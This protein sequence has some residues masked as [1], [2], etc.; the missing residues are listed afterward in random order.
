MFLTASQANGT[1]TSGKKQQIETK[2]LQW[3]INYDDLYSNSMFS[4]NSFVEINDQK[5]AASDG[6]RLYL[7]EN[8]KIIKSFDLKAQALVYIK[9]ISQIVVYCSD[10]SRL[11]FVWT[12]PPYKARI[13]PFNFYDK[14]INAM[15]YFEKS[16]VLIS[17]GNGIHFTHLTIPSQFKNSEPVP[18]ML[19]FEKICDL[20]EDIKYSF[21][22]QPIVSI[23]NEL[24]FVLL[25][26]KIFVHRSNGEL[27]Q[28]I[29]EIPGPFPLLF[30]YSEILESLIITTRDGK[31]SAL[32]FDPEETEIDYDCLQ[33]VVYYNLNYD[34]VKFVK[35]YDHN[36]MVAITQDKKILTVCIKNNRI[37]DV[38]RLKKE[39]T[40]VMEG[41]NFIYV[42]SESSL[43]R[44]K[45]NF[46]SH[47]YIEEEREIF[48]LKRCSSINF[49]ARLFYSTNTALINF[50]SRRTKATIAKIL[51]SKS[52][53]EVI[54]MIYP[55]DLNNDGETIV[56]SRQSDSLYI[57]FSKG[58]VLEINFDPI[59]YQQKQ[60]SSGDQYLVT[61]Q[62]SEIDIRKTPV[63]VISIPPDIKFVK[64]INIE[65]TKMPPCIGLI[66]ELGAICLFSLTRRQFFCTFNTQCQGVLTAIFSNYYQLIVISYVNGVAVIDPVTQSTVTNIKTNPITSL[67]MIDKNTIACGSANGT[68]EIREFPSFRL[69]YT[70]QTYGT[71]H[72][73]VS[74]SVNTGI[75]ESQK[76]LQQSNAIV[77]MDLCIQRKLILTAS[78]SGEVYL[79]DENA[80]PTI[81]LD[82]GFD[83]TSC[84]FLNGNGTIVFS[85]FNTIFKIS[86]KIL[87]DNRLVQKQLQLDDFDLRI[88]PFEPGS[89]NI[90][91]KNQKG[92]A[93]RQKTIRLSKFSS[94]E[95][96]DDFSYN[97]NSNISEFSDPQF[98]DLDVDNDAV[99][100]PKH[101][102]VESPERFR[103][104][105]PNL[106]LGADQ[107][108]EEMMRKQREA[109]EAAR[110]KK[111]TKITRT[112]SRRK[113]DENGN[114]IGVKSLYSQEPS[115]SLNNKSKSPMKLKDQTI[116]FKKELKN[117]SLTS[118][119]NKTATF[120]FD[121]NKEQNKYNQSAALSRS[122]PYNISLKKLEKQTMKR[123]EKE[124]K[125]FEKEK[126]KGKDIFEKLNRKPRE[127][128]HRQV[129][130]GKEN[131]ENTDYSTKWNGTDMVEKIPSVPKTIPNMLSSP[132][133][134][135][136]PTFASSHISRRRAESTDNSKLDARL[137]YVTPDFDNDVITEPA[138]VAHEKSPRFKS[139]PKRR[140][141]K[142]VEIEYSPSLSVQRIKEPT[143]NISTAN[144]MQDYNIDNEMFTRYKID[145]ID[146]P[147][148]G[149]TFER[150]E[151]TGEKELMQMELPP[152][153]S[154]RLIRKYYENNSNQ[155]INDPDN[156]PI[157]RVT[158][159]AN[160]IDE[161]VASSALFTGKSGRLKRI[162]EHRTHFVNYTPHE[163]FTE[164]I[165]QITEEKKEEIVV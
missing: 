76:L 82:L 88:D 109:E 95:Y 54:D 71:Y 81:H 126:K 75:T 11:T 5:Y 124:E 74:N 35:F 101:Y 52:A 4:F 116:S 104:I 98:K 142:K 39:P 141:Q 80:F 42:F 33:T 78:I 90:D 135:E 155:P 85:G 97:I 48:R 66:T 68:L 163:P 108:L 27:C 49:A 138:R 165:S 111:R 115:T 94:D 40:N 130:K 157:L 23:K 15:F 96:D 62:G 18:E 144:Q 122:A 87:Y 151:P 103:I 132:R 44:Y 37:V 24:V 34:G 6:D 58:P 10:T 2:N 61:G 72:S 84:C 32:K 7:F 106:R 118:S 143:H 51:A 86:K 36:F 59:A 13:H 102:F 19:G 17:A 79:W 14:P 145:G 1:N 152:D 110:R 158:Q 131:S 93:Q 120:S 53:K 25:G 91:L 114:I 29:Y 128:T 140:K 64:M 147:F 30:S 136:A 105:L 125:Q 67:M 139:A 22:Y 45:A 56:S 83:I 100:F 121:K 77:M 41:G 113:R 60:T 73:K 146:E 57:L 162:V 137:S 99:P 47:I 156:V 46:F 63:Q 65:S 127:S 28:T 161:L 112:T 159:N 160:H 150:Q 133:H 21:T 69:I 12:K 149:F 20:Y 134:F 31:V 26:D 3:G 38:Q 70:S 148:G 9:R 16:S 117:H 154:L 55:R 89:V 129:Y 43:Y 107:D 119:F 92:K 153:A 123:I 8:Q 164:T 50:I